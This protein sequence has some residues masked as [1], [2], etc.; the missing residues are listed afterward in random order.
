MA[1]AGGL[2]F[3]CMITGLLLATAL[4]PDL[5][6][7]GPVGERLNEDMGHAVPEEKDNSPSTLKKLTRS[8]RNISWYRR[9]P[10]FWTWYKF[11]MQTGNQEGVE[12]LDRIYLSYL[13]NKHRV[14]EGGP[15]FNHYLHHLAE[16][17]KLC[18]DSDDPECLA[19]HTSKPK[20]KVVMPKPAPIKAVCDPFTDPYCLFARMIAAKLPAPD[21]TPA[22]AP[23]P[24]KGPIPILTP[25]LPLPGNAPLGYY[26]Y[27]PVLEPFLKPE[28]RAELLRICDPTDVECLQYHL[29]AAY[30]YRPA[31]GPAPS[32]SH[33]GCDP[34]KNPF[35]KPTLVQK[36]PTGLYHL[37]PTCDPEFDPFCKPGALAPAPQA[38]KSDEAPKEQSCNPIFDDNCNPLTATK[39]AG[40]TKPVLEY[41]PT[42]EP[43]PNLACDPRYDPYCL[44]G[45]SAALL[46]S[47]P[48]MPLHQTR[49]RLG[50]KGKTK[51][52]YDCYLFYDEG[53]FPPGSKD[54]APE[55]P[56]ADSPKVACHPFDPSCGRFAPQPATAPEAS[57]SAKNG[58]IFPHPDCDPEYDYNCRLRRA[59][60]EAT[61][62]PTA[63]EGAPPEDL[64]AEEHQD[65]PTHQS[66]Y[67]SGQGDPYAGYV[68]QDHTAPRF[69]D[70]LRRYADQYG[71]FDSF[72]GGYKKK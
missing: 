35:C 41:T 23:A 2:T 28:Q 18:A 56:A 14:E 27:A 59:E 25:L 11:F 36:S 46:K 4:L 60:P 67:Q 61:A 50:F 68:A 38:A 55:A 57:K 26:Y 3:S 21:P 53:C 70:F 13:Q 72:A 64:V 16:I 54:D 52:G 39:L 49:P 8:R 40:I 33:L 69:E 47:P 58:V 29:R 32:Y 19:E 31:S 17:Y 62:A 63:D 34:K 24:I 1:R 30:G 22:K 15:N 71:R 6:G 37:Y 43:A 66:P 42:E 44:L 51:E 48:P 20:A 12:D 9:L 7:A 5:L 45:A 10:D 65:E